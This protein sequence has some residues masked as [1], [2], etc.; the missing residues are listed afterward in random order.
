MIAPSYAR[1]SSSDVRSHTACPVF[2]LQKHELECIMEM[3][4]TALVGAQTLQETDC[5]QATLLPSCAPLLSEG[6]RKA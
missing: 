2:T 1:T 5:C 3:R 6:C 4:K